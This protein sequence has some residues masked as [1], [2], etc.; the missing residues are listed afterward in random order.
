[1]IIQELLGKKVVVHIQT[2]S[3]V[4]QHRG[5][6]ESADQHFIKLKKDNETVF[7]TLIN[8][9]GMAAV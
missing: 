4:A 2:G 9:V 3:T 1:M 8:V 6:L 7:F 5:V